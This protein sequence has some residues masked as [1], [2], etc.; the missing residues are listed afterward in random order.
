MFYNQNKEDIKKRYLII[1]KGE[2]IGVKWKIITVVKCL[3]IFYN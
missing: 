2:C 3:K 1:V